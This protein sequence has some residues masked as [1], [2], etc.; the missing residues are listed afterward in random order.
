M[1]LAA[2]PLYFAWSCPWCGP[3]EHDSRTQDLATFLLVR[4]DYAWIGSG[5]AGTCSGFMAD[6]FWPP[7]LDA[8]VGAPLTPFFNETAPGVFN[9]SWTRVDVGFDCTAWKGSLAWQA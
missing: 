7:V 5:W 3:S 6:P 8:D 9:R 4:G 2:V 1:G